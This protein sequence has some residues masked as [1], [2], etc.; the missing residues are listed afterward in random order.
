MF[1]VQGDNAL[2]NAAMLPEVSKISALK[3][4]HEPPAKFRGNLQLFYGIG[5][6]Q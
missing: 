2:M 5:R 1:I 4:R 6:A 3:F